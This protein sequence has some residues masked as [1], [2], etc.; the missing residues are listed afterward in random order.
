MSNGVHI[1]QK[2]CLH[3]MSFQHPFASIPPPGKCWDA[4]VQC[5]S[6]MQKGWLGCHSGATTCRKNL[7]GA[8]IPRWSRIKIS[9]M[10]P[11]W[12]WWMKFGLSCHCTFDFVNMFQ[13]VFCEQCF[14]SQSS[15]QCLFNLL[16]IH[17]YGFFADRDNKLENDS[18]RLLDS[19]ATNPMCTCR[20]Y[21]GSAVV[22]KCAKA[23]EAYELSGCHLHLLSFPWFSNIR[24]WW[25]MM[26]VNDG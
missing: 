1:H 23:G 4:D 10:H 16:C 17:Y 13:C 21:L 24:K 8:K 3:F 11:T 19:Q 20:G 15:L 14:S 22:T 25:L 26:M 7:E 12:A 18:F 2:L 5:R 9:K 6:I